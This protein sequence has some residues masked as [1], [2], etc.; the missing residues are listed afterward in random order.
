M[1]AFVKHPSA[2]DAADYSKTTG[3]VLLL[4]SK[5]DSDMLPIYEDLKKKPFGSVCGH[6]RFDDMFHGWYACWDW[7]R[8]LLTAEYPQVR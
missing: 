3:P 5:D 2:V 6:Q 8:L 7:W 1:T 4:P